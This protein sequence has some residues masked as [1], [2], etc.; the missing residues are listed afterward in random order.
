MLQD[1]FSLYVSYGQI[2]IFARD[3]RNP[4]NDW[5]ERH[6][7]QGFAWRPGSV[8]F[9]TLVESAEHSVEVEVVDHAFPVATSVIRAIEV[10]F[11]VP[12]SGKLEVASVSDSVLIDVPAGSYSLRCELFGIEKQSHYRVHLL[13]SKDDTPRFVVIRSDGEVVAETELLTSAQ[14]AK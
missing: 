14:P 2:V 10:P 4:F 5:S 3:V 13:F 9:R 7:A 6:V 1:K 12:A 8:S 11:R